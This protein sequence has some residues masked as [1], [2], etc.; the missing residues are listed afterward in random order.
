MEGKRWGEGVWE[1]VSLLFWLRSRNEKN[2][3]CCLFSFSWGGGGI[4]EIFMSFLPHIY[5]NVLSN[6][7]IHVVQPRPSFVRHKAIHRRAGVIAASF[8]P[9]C[10]ASTCQQHFSQ[11][12]QQDQQPA[13]PQEQERVRPGLCQ[14]GESKSK[15]LLTFQ[16]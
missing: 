14:P 9:Q 3:S 2:F 16:F 1:R 7:P 10:K 6:F 11:Q 12:Q 13:S 4:E 5:C 15:Y 8:P